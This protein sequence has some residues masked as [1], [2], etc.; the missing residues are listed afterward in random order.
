MVKILPSGGRNSTEVCGRGTVGNRDFAVILAGENKSC[1]F[2][3]FAD[4]GK[5]TNPQ[6]RRD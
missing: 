3:A 4:D 2:G 6:V 5:S 1:V